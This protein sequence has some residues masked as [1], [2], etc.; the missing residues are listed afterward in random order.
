MRHRNGS[1]FFVRLAFPSR[2]NDGLAIRL[3]IAGEQSVQR[4]LVT[5]LGGKRP[6][7]DCGCFSFRLFLLSAINKN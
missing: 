2:K 6:Q 4:T 5:N 3:R 1:P 7:T